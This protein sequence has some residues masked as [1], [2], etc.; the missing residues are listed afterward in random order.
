MKKIKAMILL[1]IIGKS[2]SSIVVTV[3]C[4][5]AS[6]KLLSMINTISFDGVATPIALSLLILGLASILNYVIWRD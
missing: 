3:P 2:I 4:I 5:V 6:I 1:T